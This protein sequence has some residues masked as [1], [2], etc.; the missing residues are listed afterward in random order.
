MSSLNGAA[1]SETRWRCGAAVL[2]LLLCAGC[3]DALNKLPLVQGGPGADV[4]RVGRLATRVLAGDGPDT[5]VG[6]P[7]GDDLSGNAD[8]DSILG[9]PGNDTEHGGKG[10]DTLDGGLGDDW[11]A[12]DRGHDVL[13]GGPGRDHFVLALG[14]G[15]ARVT[16]FDGPGGDRVEV[17]GPLAPQIVATPQG[18][19][20][21]L[22]DGSRL[23]LTGVPRAGLER[24]I[25]R[26]SPA[27]GLALC[28]GLVLAAL[29]G[30]LVLYRT[31]LPRLRLAGAGAPIAQSAVGP[32][33]EGAA[34]P[35]ED[36]LPHAR[37]RSL[38]LDAMRAAA[39]GIVLVFHWVSGVL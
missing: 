22:A 25:S 7:R 16:D 27:P 24:W 37:N 19:V 8:N 35:L 36:L 29:A 1:N 38:G 6:G 26:R 9:G 15:V 2:C 21:R 31:T 5:I 4:I 12:G 34:P 13:T 20:V 10:D 39:I 18:A 17:E 3:G 28:V 14:G 23:L 30:L 11:L 33:G 32:S